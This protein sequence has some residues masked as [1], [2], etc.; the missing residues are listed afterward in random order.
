MSFFRNFICLFIFAT[1]AY[2]QDF[3]EFEMPTD[4]YIRENPDLLTLS[5]WP[6]GIA[7]EAVGEVP[8]DLGFHS[9]ALLQV[10]SGHAEAGL[11]IVGEPNRWFSPKDTVGQ[12]ANYLIVFSRLKGVDARNA[13]VVY[14]GRDIDLNVKN[15]HPEVRKLLSA[16]LPIQGP[17]CF[18]A[19]KASDNNEV[20]A[21]VLVVDTEIS[22]T[23]QKACID[24]MVPSSLGVLP[25]FSSLDLSKSIG[26]QTSSDELFTD[27]SELTFLL[28]A[29]AYCR[30]SL[31]DYSLQ[32]PENVL[33]A[34]YRYHES[35]LESTEKAN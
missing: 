22:V 31:E 26:K 12:D 16:G 13:T 34:V 35:L 30:N 7:F 17:G 20:H 4:R 5:H 33:S 28:R 19:W 24:W 1:Q 21:F 18:A 3:S 25:V 2:G 10:M 15:A 14:I 32:C 8:L 6:E 23:K 29:S 27:K 11:S 9:A